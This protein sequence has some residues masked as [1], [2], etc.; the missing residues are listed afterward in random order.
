MSARHP[1][2]RRLPGCRMPKRRDAM[3]RS[4]TTRSRQDAQPDTRARSIGRA[5]P[6]TVKIRSTASPLPDRFEFQQEQGTCRRHVPNDAVSHPSRSRACAG[7]ASGA[8]PTILSPSGRRPAMLA[9]EELGVAI[10]NTPALE[11]RGGFSLGFSTRRERSPLS[12]RSVSWDPVIRQQD[13]K[14]DLEMTWI[15]STIL[16]VVLTIVTAVQANAS[17]NDPFQYPGS[18]STCM[19]D[20]FSMDAESMTVATGVFPFPMP[21]EDH[22][23]SGPKWGFSSAS[24]PWEFTKATR[25]PWTADVTMAFA[26]PESNWASDPVAV[27]IVEFFDAT[28]F[29]SV[30][31]DRFVR[32]AIAKA[33]EE[34]N[35]FRRHGQRFAF[36]QHLPGSAASVPHLSSLARNR[37]GDHGSGSSSFCRRVADENGTMPLVTNTRAAV[38]GGRLPPFMS[39]RIHKMPLCGNCRLARVWWPG[40]LAC[41]RTAET[42]SP[43][44]WR[45]T[46]EHE[47]P[48][49]G[50]AQLRRTRCS[51]RTA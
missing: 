38:K 24:G 11:R 27:R 13:K 12:G 2:L 51:P 15:T 26:M 34:P 46:W 28:P 5:S 22:H 30:T 42:R 47:E 33:M 48:L 37:L 45:R 10:G 39:H 31:N 50:P 20:A 19:V 17:C 4:P 8:S 43:W 18:D 44:P 23:R 9:K 1:V 14:G 6:T 40:G 16:A 49:W 35:R 32:V 29:D 41:R 25:S 36:R 21:S 7:R 3:P